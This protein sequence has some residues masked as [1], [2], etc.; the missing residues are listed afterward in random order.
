MNFKRLL[1]AFWLAPVAGAVA[2]TAMFLVTDHRPSHAFDLSSA[3]ILFLVALTFSYASALL[4]GAPLIYLLDATGQKQWPAYLSLGLLC[5]FLAVLVV[6]LPLQMPAEAVLEMWQVSAIGGAVG[7]LAF[8]WLAIRRD[9][10]Q[11]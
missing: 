5:A 9:T 1:M 7:G 10:A 6:G 3:F 11:A 4:F 2:V 8:W